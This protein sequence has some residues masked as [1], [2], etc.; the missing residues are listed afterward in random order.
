MK[1]ILRKQVFRYST[2]RTIHI[3]NC[4][5]LKFMGRESDSMIYLLHS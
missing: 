3:G 4:R 5:C 1:Q 2:D